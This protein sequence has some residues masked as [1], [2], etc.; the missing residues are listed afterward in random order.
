MHLSR[1]PGRCVSRTKLLQITLTRLYSMLCS[2]GEGS[3]LP[4]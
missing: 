4:L 1:R 2:L 3:A